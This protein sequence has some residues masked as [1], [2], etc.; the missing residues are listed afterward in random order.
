MALDMIARSAEDAKYSL[1]SE[2]E[3]EFL[4]HLSQVHSMI[5][6]ILTSVGTHPGAIKQKYPNGIE[7]KN[8]QGGKEH[9]EEHKNPSYENPRPS[10]PRKPN[11]P[12]GYRYY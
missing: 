7:H 2:D 11:Y 1:E 12:A 8:R 9:G 6:S 3:D 10:N 4:Y 5:E